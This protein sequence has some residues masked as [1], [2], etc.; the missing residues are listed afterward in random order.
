MLY[1]NNGSKYWWVSFR[2][3]KRPGKFI[4]QSTGTTSIKDARSIEESM[5]LSIKGKIS[6]MKLKSILD[7]VFTREREGAGLPIAQLWAT[8][9]RFMSMRDR[10]PGERLVK[11][12]KKNLEDFIEWTKTEFPVTTV[13]EVTF[14]CAMAYAE[15]LKKKSSPKD[16]KHKAKLKDKSRK[17]YIGN[18]STIWKAAEAL[19]G[20]RNP[21]KDLRP[22]VRDGQR[23][24]AFTRAQEKAVLAAAKASAVPHWYE[25]CLVAR[26]TGLRKHDVVFLEWSKVDFER[27]VI[28][29][30]PIKTQGYNIE[31]EVPMVAVLRD[32]LKGLFAKRRKYVLPEFAK[33][34]PGD[35]ED[36]TFAEILKAAKVDD[37]TITFHSWRHTFRTRLAEAGVSDDL[38]KRLGGWTQDATVKRYDH[39]DKT[40]EIRRALESTS[41]AA[42]P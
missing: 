39:A 3:P 12:R 16:K 23:H 4:R 28:R 8:Y 18:L 17:E 2:D 1:K 19:Y 10:K 26:W 42:R 37:P 33:I 9:E 38:A 32:A 21:W 25:A 27:G 20:V 31:V 11:Q 6:E 35:P 15:H 24:A 22:T 7:A 36:C 41:S 34:Y 30:K 5:H 40:E 14:E 29:V 13:E